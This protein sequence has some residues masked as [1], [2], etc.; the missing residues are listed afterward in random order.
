[1]WGETYFYPEDYVLFTVYA[2]SM[3]RMLWKRAIVIYKE[4][5]LYRQD[6]SKI[7]KCYFCFRTFL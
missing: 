6:L 2:I 5:S 3:E 7:L 1:M 4:G